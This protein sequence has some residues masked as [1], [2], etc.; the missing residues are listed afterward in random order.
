MNK[1]NKVLI[2]RFSSIGDIVL[3]SPVIRCL[4][5]QK[6]TEIH[7]LT[8]SIFKE[9]LE[10]NIYIDKL[11]VIEKSISEVFKQLKS[12][13]YDYV[14]DLHNNIRSNIL[15]LKLFRPTRRYSKSLFNRFRLLKLGAKK[16][17]IKHV[18]E[19]YLDTLR[20][21]DIKND[22]K[23]LDF[24][25]HNEI[26]VLINEPNY[27]TWCIGA[28][29]SNKKLPVKTIID[30][31][32]NIDLP[33]V[34]LGGKEDYNSGQQIMKISKSNKI[35]N[36]CGKASVSESAEII[37][38]SKALFSNDTG[39]M[40]IG[41]AFNKPIISFWGCTKPSLGF[42]P[43]KITNSILIIA[44]PS[45]KPCSKHGKQCNNGEDKACLSTITS[46]EILK[47]Y[48]NLFFKK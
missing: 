8:K 28:S 21:F 44:N 39:M 15:T 20:F 7:Y 18:A 30:T 1:K 31:C 16:I 37:K 27:L 19:R 40:H 13:N 5:K 41:A 17:Q 24:F 6:N 36:F 43:Y 3:T 33:I 38:K 34:L 12:E 4:K 9:I 47:Q 29:N 10:E 48:K 2:I 35:Y 25:V 23:G 11:Y 42:T 45:I 46:A 22:N 26:N 32:N 14:I